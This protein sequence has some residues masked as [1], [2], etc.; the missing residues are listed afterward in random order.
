MSSSSA[1][2]P[3]LEQVSSLFDMARSHHP[4][5]QMKK[6][7]WVK[8]PQKIATRSGTLWEKSFTGVNQPNITICVEELEEL[9]S[10]KEIIHQKSQP[11]VNKTDGSAKPTAVNILDQRISLNMSIFLKQFKTSNKNIVAIINE[12]DHTKISID[13][14]KALQKLLPDKATVSKVTTVYKSSI[15]VMNTD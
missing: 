14:L 2:S 5:K 8:V 15:L 1:G 7:N 4:K 12:G 6:L 10:R 3:H 9:F 11:L 13:Q